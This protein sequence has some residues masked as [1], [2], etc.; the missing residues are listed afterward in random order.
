MQ[1]APGRT[2]T[3]DPRLRRPSLSPVFAGD[4]PQMGHE[5]AKFPGAARYAGGASRRRAR[6]AARRT[7]ASA[8]R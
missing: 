2:R 4:L 5:W 1:S 3:C 6:F 7:V 8:E